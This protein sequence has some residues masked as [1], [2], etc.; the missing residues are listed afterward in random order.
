LQAGS[1]VDVTSS[2]WESE[3]LKAD[4]VV[5]VDF[6]APYCPHCRALMPIFEELAS[7][8]ADRMKFVKLNVQDSSDV[9]TKYGVMGIPTLKFFCAGRP[10]REQ[11]GGLP[12]D[13]LRKLL[14][15]VLVNHQSCLSKSSP[16][17]SD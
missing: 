4:K 3:V 12:K 7:E 6:W 10:V 1:A 14:D 11:V 17:S 15:D 13:S 5:V 2:N 8:Y 9:A 16:I